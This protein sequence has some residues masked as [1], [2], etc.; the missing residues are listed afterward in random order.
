MLLNVS[1]LLPWAG[2]LF[3]IAAIISLLVGRLAKDNDW[4]K[5]GKIMAAIGI[6]MMILTY[7]VIFWLKIIILCEGF[8]CTV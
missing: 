1:A 4:L 8:S 6:T 2:I 7:I 5:A 3:S